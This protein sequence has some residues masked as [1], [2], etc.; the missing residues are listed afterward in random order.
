MKNKDTFGIY[1][2]VKILV[3]THLQY[4]G[5]KASPFGFSSDLPPACGDCKNPGN[6]IKL[7]Y[8]QAEKE[9]IAFI[10]DRAKPICSPKEVVRLFR[11]SCFGFGLLG[12]RYNDVYRK[13][14]GKPVPSEDVQLSETMRQD[15]NYQ[16]CKLETVDLDE[17]F[18]SLDGEVFSLGPDYDAIDQIIYSAYNCGLRYEKD[19]TALMSVYLLSHL[20][21]SNFKMRT[22]SMTNGLVSAA[23]VECV[24]DS[25]W[26]ERPLLGYF[27]CE[28]AL[29]LSDTYVNVLNADFVRIFTSKIDALFA[30]ATSGDFLTTGLKNTLYRIAVKGY[31]GYD[32]DVFSTYHAVNEILDLHERNATI[33]EAHICSSSYRDNINYSVALPR[34]DVAAGLTYE[35]NKT[36]LNQFCDLIESLGLSDMDG[37]TALRNRIRAL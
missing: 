14:M 26:K 16:S 19:A 20:N 34:Q 8:K 25:S 27:D 9:M 18:A 35:V 6:G 36:G 33:T 23:C 31:F 21:R 7:Q 2:Q 10:N 1:K 32:A 30:S 3:E 24:T 11:S 15:V 12:M 5:T 28:N 13:T 22:D 4:E 29:S 37:F 17:I